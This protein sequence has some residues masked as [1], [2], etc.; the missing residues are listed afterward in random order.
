MWWRD[1]L[2]RPTYTIQE[3]DHESTFHG[4]KHCNVLYLYFPGDDSP[5]PYSVPGTPYDPLQALPP[6]AAHDTKYLSAVIKEYNWLTSSGMTNSQGLYVDGFHTTCYVSP[7][8]IGTGNCDTCD[9]SVF[10]YNQGA[11]LSG[12]RGL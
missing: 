4:I 8:D 2:D 6:A 12:V 10:S 5:E 3:H 11:F 9:E 1:G 7:S